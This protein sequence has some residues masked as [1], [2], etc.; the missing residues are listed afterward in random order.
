MC[1]M[2][3]FSPIFC[4]IANSVKSG[5]NSEL[6]TLAAAFVSG[7]Q[8]IAISFAFSSVSGAQFNPAISFALW[9]TGK[10]SNRRALLYILVQLLA[11]ILSMVVVACV[12]HGNLE[13]VYDSIAVTPKDKTELGRVFATEFFLTF[14]LT[15]VAFTV[16]FEDAENQKKES[17]SFQT[18]SDSKGLTLYASTPQSKTGF[19]PFA[20]GLTIFSL[21]LVGGTSGGAFNPARLLGPA[22]FSGS[23]DYQ[24]LY[25]L[26]DICGSS[27]AALLV[28]NMH[29]IGLEPVRKNE[30]TAKEVISKTLQNKEI[31]TQAAIGSS[32]TN[33]PLNNNV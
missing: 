32:G 27:C 4:C 24:Y 33:N 5:W 8:A 6:T 7:F 29:R 21:N 2:L 20:I 23:W 15:Y 22:I 10:L 17:M 19:A 1:T 14:F 3:F 31:I 12:F 30:V 28:N 18:I 26:G 9:L 16:A 13:S 11:S 25:W